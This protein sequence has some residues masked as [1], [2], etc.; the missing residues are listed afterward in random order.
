MRALAYWHDL[1]ARRDDLLLVWDAEDIVRAKEL[2][3]LGVVFHFQ[4]TTPLDRDLKLVRAYRELGVRMI[5]LTY[6]VKNAV[7]D[8]CE[9]LNDSGLSRFGVSLVKELNRQRIVVDCS[10][11][12]DRTTLEAIEVSEHP[13]VCSHSNSRVLKKTARNVPDD[14]ID[15]IAESGGLLGM[16]GSAGFVSSSERSTLDEFVDHIDYIVDRVGPNHVGVAVDYWQGM[17]LVAT[18]AEAQALFEQ[19]VESGQW[20]PENYPAPPL[21][22]PIGLDTPRELPNLTA[23]LLDR[24]YG[25]EDVAKI[26]GGNW[27]RVFRAVWGHT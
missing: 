5:Q 4:G 1:I 3:K 25:E 19:F 27:L 9:E 13:V 7:G 26:M 20:Q 2:G 22:Y 16:N 8:G 18:Q 10:H 11:T 12:G 24:G 14:I 6:N 21:Y 17:A 15:A 23:K